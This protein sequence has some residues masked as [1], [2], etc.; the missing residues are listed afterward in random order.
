MRSVNHSK[1]LCYLLR[2]AQAQRYR[3]DYVL[4]QDVLE[5]H[6]LSVRAAGPGF[7]TNAQSLESFIRDFSLTSAMVR[8]IALKLA[9]SAVYLCGGG[10]LRQIWTSSKIWFVERGEHQLSLQPH[11][12]A[13]LPNRNRGHECDSQ[14]FGCVNQLNSPH[15][16]QLASLG[17]M[18]MELYSG[19]TAEQFLGD[20]P[21]CAPPRDNIY[22]VAGHFYEGY[23]ETMMLEDVQYL[24]AVYACLHPDLRMENHESINW[25]ILQ[26][27]TLR[28]IVGPL[29][30][31][32]NNFYGSSDG[33]RKASSD[34]DVNLFDIRQHATPVQGL[35]SA[36]PTSA[37]VSEMVTNP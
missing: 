16:L 31:S 4:Q 7:D 23:R 27:H 19:E 26:D 37:D 28:K 10:L 22:A 6:Q 34:E 20:E 9:W 13:D 1:A 17:L 5:F 11:L 24:D 14:C 18:L 2:A 36:T 29:Y 3:L 35:S 30:R 15:H 25:E 32:L 8:V 21:N 12:G 33:V